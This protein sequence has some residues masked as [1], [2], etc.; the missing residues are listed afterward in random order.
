MGFSP[1]HPATLT[2][3]SSFWATFPRES[4]AV[5]NAIPSES[6]LPEGRREA[7]QPTAGGVGNVLAPGDS[8]PASRTPWPPAPPG[9]KRPVQDND[10]ASEP[11]IA[12]HRGRCSGGPGSPAS[13]QAPVA[14]G[15]LSLA[16]LAEAVLLCRRAPSWPGGGAGRGQRA[17][18]SVGVR[19]SVRWRSCG[20]CPRRQ[21]YNGRLGCDGNCHLVNGR[22]LANVCRDDRW[23]AD[24]NK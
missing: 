24:A 23:N 15:H 17:W 22:H 20:W 11:G 6:C 4:T 18:V 8:R 14:A 19:V 13:A 10:S 3:V 7:G 12:G 21:Y 2:V 5:F 1:G 16:G 9:W